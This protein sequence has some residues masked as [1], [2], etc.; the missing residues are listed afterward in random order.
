[1]ACDDLQRHWQQSYWPFSYSL[2]AV[3]FVQLE[4]LP[5]PRGITFPAFDDITHQYEVV[6]H[7]KQSRETGV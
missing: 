2:P 4:L 6:S 5:Q 7:A 3:P 1:M